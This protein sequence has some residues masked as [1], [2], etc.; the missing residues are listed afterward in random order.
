MKTIIL[1]S[2]LAASCR[3]TDEA[4]LHDGRRSAGRRLRHRR[5]GYQREIITKLTRG[6][7]KPRMSP[8]SGSSTSRSCTTAPA[9]PLSASRS[10][11]SGS[12]AAWTS[13]TTR[14]HIPTSTRSPA[15]NTSR[16]SF[17]VR[18]SRSKLL[19]RRGRTLRYFR[20]PFLYLGSTKEMAD[21]LSTFLAGRKLHNR[22]CHGRQRRLHV[23]RD[24]SPC[25]MHGAIRRT[26]RRSGGSTWRTWRR[27][28]GTTSR[29]R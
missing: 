27:S 7:R 15:S 14:T 19:H 5:H 28:C 13:G 24:V 17:A 1:I 4:T 18:P 29:N 9:S 16:M 6:L 2:L 10:L 22:A 3:G 25:A 12:T 26:R 23:R 20:H 8:P 21:S 11:S